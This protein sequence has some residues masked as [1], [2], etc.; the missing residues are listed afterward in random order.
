MTINQEFK[1]RFDELADGYYKIRDHVSNFQED[2]ENLKSK[3]QIEIDCHEPW[4]KALM[5]ELSRITS[6]FCQQE[7]VLHHDYIKQTPYFEYSLEAPFY[8]QI[9]AKP[10][11]YAGDAEMMQMIYRDD[12]EGQ[13]P[14][15]ML[16]HKHATS[17]ASCQAVRNRKDFL[18]DQIRKLESGKVLS[19]AAGPA[20]E[21]KTFLGPN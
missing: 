20:E 3:L 13:T 10:N 12:F 2:R 1:K 7:K 8:R 16:L 5:G 15:G 4:R 18:I 21:I 17:T 14:F 9:I 11:G 6:K 19:L